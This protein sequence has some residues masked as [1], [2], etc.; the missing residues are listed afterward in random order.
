MRWALSS[1][2][3]S[4]SASAARPEL[5]VV[6]RVLHQHLV[7]AHR[8]HRVVEAV[9]AALRV[10]FDVVERVGVHHR[11]RRPRPAVHRGHGGDHLR[12]AS[13]DSGQKGQAAVPPARDRHVVAGD[14]PGAR[15]GIFAKFHWQLGKPLSAARV[16][17][18]SRATAQQWLSIVRKTV[19][20]RSSG[21]PQ[22][23][24][25]RASFAADATTLPPRSPWPMTEPPRR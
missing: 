8:P 4:I 14:H 16:N 6:A 13:V 22:L 20:S 9:A 2:N 23:A 3:C 12:C 5:A 7:R 10:A 25:I 17:F 19:S 11:P 18:G 21:A 24:I 1:R 15:D